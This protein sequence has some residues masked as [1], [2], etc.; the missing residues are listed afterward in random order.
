M[1]R[2]II[3]IAS[4]SGLLA[5]CMFQAAS[6]VPTP[7]PA[8]YLPTVV[9]LTGQAAYAASS[10]LTETAVPAAAT[11]TPLPSSTP[12]PTD[13]PTPEPGFSEF[14]QIRFLSPGPMSKIVS[15]LQLQMLVV[16]GERE[17]VQIDLLGEDGRK[18]YGRL[19]RVNRRPL[20]VYRTLKIPFEIRAAAELGW[21]QVSAKDN[22]GRLQA[23]N[24]VRVLLLSAGTDEIN[25]P[26]NIIYERAVLETPREKAVISG[27]VLDVVGRMWPVNETPVYLELI[28]PDGNVAGLRQLGFKG[29]EPQSFETTIPYKLPD[30]DDKAASVQGRLTVRQM[31]PILNIPLYVFTR[32]VELNP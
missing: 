22:D 24:S 27:G 25:P 29:L 19:E 1:F 21:L 13:T 11:L 10:A 20:G 23:L 6:P 32:E 16:S 8:D 5:G 15:P 12:L 4:F 9:A 28:L 17:I 2:R 31:D 14:A 18:L 30:S 3:L 26:G 7:Y